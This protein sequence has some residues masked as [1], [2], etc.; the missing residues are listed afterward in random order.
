MLICTTSLF[1]HTTDVLAVRAAIPL[2]EDEGAEPHHSPVDTPRPNIAPIGNE[3]LQASP[4]FHRTTP[5]G[6]VVLPHHMIICILVCI[7]SIS[8]IDHL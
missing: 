7:S 1:P 5:V 4:H 8:I 6:D 3:W 2:G